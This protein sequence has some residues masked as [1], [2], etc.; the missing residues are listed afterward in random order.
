MKLNERGVEVENLRE[1][2]PEKGVTQGAP[3]SPIL[4]SVFINGLIEELRQQRVGVVV[5]N[6]RR[7]GFMFADDIALLVESINE[8]H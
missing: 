5:R 6:T 8:V 4:Y 2:H 7:P 1:F 3:E